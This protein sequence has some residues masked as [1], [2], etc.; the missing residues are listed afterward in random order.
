MPYSAAFVC[1]TATLQNFQ[2]LE[3]GDGYGQFSDAVDNL[4]LYELDQLSTFYYDQ[5]RDFISFLNIQD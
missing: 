3:L 5:I 4:T 1:E 2:E